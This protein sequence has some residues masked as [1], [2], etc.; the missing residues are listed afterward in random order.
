MEVHGPSATA[1]REPRLRTD[2]GEAATGSLVEV[3]LQRDPVL[4]ASG[5]PN[6]ARGTSKGEKPRE[7]RAAVV[8]NGDRSYRPGFRSKASKVTVGE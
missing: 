3:N 5:G 8:G 2:A 1:G 7:E 6:G 4:R